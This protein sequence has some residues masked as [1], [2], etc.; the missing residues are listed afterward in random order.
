MASLL[1]APIFRAFDSNG[2]PLAGGRVFTYQAGT[3]IPLAS[4]T[5]QSGTVANTNPVIL[6][7]TGSANIWLVGSYKIDL[8]S[9]NN[10]QQ[11]NFPVDNIQDI[12]T[13]IGGAYG[14]VLNVW[15]GTSGG[16]AN[17]L[18]LTPSPAITSLIVGQKLRF[19]VFQDN[20]G[21]ATISTSGGADI[22]IRKVDNSG[23]LV[24][25]TA[26]DL[27]A[28]DIAEVSYDGTY[29]QLLNPAIKITYAPN[30]QVR[31]TRTGGN[32][33][34]LPYT[35]TNLT[36]NRAVQQVPTAGV[37]LSST[38]VAA[39]TL[40]YIY[41][42]MNGN[43][44]TLEFSITGHST[45]TTSGVEI[46]TGDVTR[47][48]VGMAY[49]TGTNTWGTGLTDLANWYNRLP[50][51]QDTAFTAARSG[52]TTLAEINTEIRNNFLSWN[53]SALICYNGQVVQNTGVGTPYTYIYLDGTAISG[54]GGTAAAAGY[55]VPI[56][57]SK[58]VI[59]T[60]GRHTAT[61]FGN[62]STNTATWQSSINF[63]GNGILSV[64]VMI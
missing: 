5:D 60:E 58:P 62:T 59:V 20:T 47:T 22:A 25:L 31:L 13:Q 18:S 8:R 23:A 21:G 57:S 37:S 54:T 44:M 27:K 35:G 46:K 29:W 17:Q 2:L 9:S 40:Y 42:Y 55:S 15:A 43:V 48:L 39:T 56:G 6:D 50:V 36:I 49:A 16:L 30:G 26:G 38:G 34:M 12:Q 61:I 19:K 63:V 10:V 3:N 45:D 41:A 32:I 4:Y 52:T 28:N 51:S 64:Q 11:P 1:P 7:S 33:V 53:T 14:N 24:A